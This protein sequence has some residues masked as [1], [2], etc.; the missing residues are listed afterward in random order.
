MDSAFGDT[1]KTSLKGLMQFKGSMKGNMDTAQS[2]PFDA[3]TTTGSVRWY[4][5]PDRATAARFYSGLIF[6][7]LSVTV[8]LSGRATFSGSFTG[9]GALASA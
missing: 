7:K 8:P 4:L 1:W 2:I 5:Y 6:P 9:D 3:A